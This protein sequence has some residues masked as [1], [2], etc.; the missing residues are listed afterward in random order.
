MLV[1]YAEPANNSMPRT[2]RGIYESGCL[3]CAH[4]STSSGQAPAGRVGMMVPARRVGDFGCKMDGGPL[5]SK[6]LGIL[7]P[8]A[9]PM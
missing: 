4:P 7:L 5:S 6:A 1:S 3:G 9:G 8:F 2:Q